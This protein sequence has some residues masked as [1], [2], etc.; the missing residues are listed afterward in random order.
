MDVPQGTG[1]AEPREAE[2]GGAVALGDVARIVGAHEID[3]QAA[4][5]GPLQGAQPVADL[6]EADAEGLGQPLDVVAH[7][8]GLGGEGPIGH[9]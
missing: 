5:A 9:Q 6:F 7:G 4:F 2:T 3:R 1:A 8:G